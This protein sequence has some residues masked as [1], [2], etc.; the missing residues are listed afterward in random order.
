MQ[1]E[2]EYLNLLNEKCESF[3]DFMYQLRSKEVTVLTEERRSGPA[4]INMK[5]YIICE[6][7]RA[8][9]KKLMQL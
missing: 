8:Q 9:K 2:S 7:T 5:T 6:A 3:L 4:P 1:Y